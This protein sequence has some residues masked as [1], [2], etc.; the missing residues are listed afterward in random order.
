MMDLSAITGFFVHIS[1]D[2]IFLASIGLLAF[3]DAM[4]GGGARAIALGLAFPLSYLL[5]Q[6]A[7]KAQL[8]SGVESQLSS[9]LAQGAFALSL[10]AICFFMLY[11]VA[12]TLVAESG[13]V[14]S[15]AAAIG[16]CAMI[17]LFWPLIPGLMALHA[18]AAQFLQA[19]GDA[20][21][22]WLILVGLAAFAF[23]R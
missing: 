22:F 9:T 5:T 19:F 23:S 20:Y 10:I 7:G 1:I 14:Q 21:R 8:L 6:F 3:L 16:L 17:G 11:R 4:R 13:F 2:W 15:L 18:P 12:D